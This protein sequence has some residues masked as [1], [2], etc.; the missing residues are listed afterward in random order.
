MSSSTPQQTPSGAPNP[1]SRHRFKRGRGRGQQNSTSSTHEPS[2]ADTNAS[3]EPQAE[4]LS[5]AVPPFESSQTANTNSRGNGQR[6]RGGRGGR[7][8]RRGGIERNVIAGPGGRVFG[9]QLT[10][11]QQ[12]ASIPMSGP[13]PASLHADSPEFRPGQPVRVRR[14]VSP[15]SPNLQMPTNIF[16]SSQNRKEATAPPRPRRPSKSNAPDIAS[17]THEDIANGLYECPIC[18]SEV[19]RNSK[20]WSCKTCWTVFHLSCIKKWSK[21]EGSTQQ[22]QQ[23]PEGEIPPPRQWRCPGCNLPKDELPTSYTCWCAKEIDPKPIPGLPPHSCGQTC[24]KPRTPRKCPHPCELLCHAGPCP[25]CPHMGPKMSCYCGKESVARR[26]VDTNYEA[27]WSC[28]KICGDLMPCGEHTCKRGCHEGLCG[29]CDVLVESRCYCGKVAK[30]IRCSERG[31]QKESSLRTSLFR[32]REII[33]KGIV[34]PNSSS[35]SDSTEEST[36]SKVQQQLP[37]S[38]KEIYKWVGSFD[39][40]STCSRPYDCKKHYCEQGCHVQTATEPHCPLSPDIVKSCP[41]GKTRLAD[42][43]CERESCEDPVPF[44]EKLCL[45]RLPCGHQCRQKCHNG[46]CKPCEQVISVN[47]RCGRTTSDLICYKATEEP[48]ECS[49]FCKTLLNCGRHECGKQC[50]PGEKA[51]SERQAAKRKQRS[52]ANTGDDFEAEHIC[53]RTCGRVLKCGNPEHTCQEL[54]H[55]GQCGSCREAIFDELACNCGRTIL[56]PPLPCGTQPPACQ[57]QCTRPKACGHPQVSHG[58]HGDNESCPKCPYLVQKACMCG[59]KILKNQPC[60]STQIS[61]GQTCG[62][63][64]RCG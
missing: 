33:I 4:A 14:F 1:R 41:C 7:P 47:C 25:P 45:R 12:I 51:A 2:D 34:N 11:E 59:K 21:N 6:G 15:S 37:E 44:C 17:R 26:C 53:T 55:R 13:S 10:R 58:C 52:N 64:L 27:G 40:G 49:R 38:D 19:L 30:A 57:Y 24:S 54:C 8:S 31:E 23:V 28:G 46:D 29:S 60:W 5:G 35:P 36:I 42:M 9:G 32:E 16:Y 48:P 18:T 20:V 43:D 62:H 22:R 61:C 63:K 3:A 50:C 39:C 56:H